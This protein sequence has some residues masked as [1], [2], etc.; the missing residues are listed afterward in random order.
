MVSPEGQKGGHTFLTHVQMITGDS[1]IMGERRN[2]FG[3]CNWKPE[4]TERDY[5]TDIDI[6]FRIILKYAKF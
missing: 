3:I 5:V 1:V 6:G 4:Q 2:T